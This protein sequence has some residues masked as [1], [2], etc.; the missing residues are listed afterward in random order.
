MPAFWTYGLILIVNVE[1]EENILIKML[2]Q[3]NLKI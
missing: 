2:L 3:E 1:Y